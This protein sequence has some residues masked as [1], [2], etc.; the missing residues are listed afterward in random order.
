MKSDVLRD[1]DPS[2]FKALVEEGIEC[3]KRMG[4]KALELAPR[5]VTL[6]MPVAGNESHIGTIYAGILFTVA[7]VPGGALFLTTF[8]VSRYVPIVKGMEI[9]FKKPAFTDVTVTVEMSQ[10]EVDRIHRELEEKGKSDFTLNAEVKD[11]NGTVVAESI[12]N[13]Q[14]RDTGL[15]ILA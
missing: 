13:Y 7:E 4:L 15:G 3:V 6:Q 11:A 1:V 12:G 10:E 8:D 2:Q 9:K 14:I 5:R